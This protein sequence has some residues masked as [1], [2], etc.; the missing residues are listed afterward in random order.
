MFELNKINGGLVKS[1]NLE[2]S[3]FLNV[4]RMFTNLYFESGLP[5]ETI[6]DEFINIELENQILGFIVS[7]VIIDGL[8]FSTSNELKNYLFE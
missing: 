8:T 7:E 4:P 1:N 6:G 5:Y 2:I 3:H